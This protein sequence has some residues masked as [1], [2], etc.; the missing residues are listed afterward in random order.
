MIILYKLCKN[1]NI[2]EQ[3]SPSDSYKK[4][5]FGRINEIKLIVQT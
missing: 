3:W 5:N 4:L 1:Y 2:Y